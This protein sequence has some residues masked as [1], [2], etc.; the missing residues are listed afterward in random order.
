MGK[1]FTNK[2]TG[3]SATDKT[4]EESNAAKSLPKHRIQDGVTLKNSTRTMNLN[5]RGKNSERWGDGDPGYKDPYRRYTI[6]R[7]LATKDRRR[8]T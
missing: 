7:R 8:T 2:G 4:A 1:N 6:D 5:R 3:N